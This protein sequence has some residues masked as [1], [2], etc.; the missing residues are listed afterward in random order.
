MNGGRIY[1]QGTLCGSPT[2]S[3]FDLDNQSGVGANDMSA[4]LGDFATGNP[5]GRSDYDCSGGLGA[6][7]LSLWLSAFGAGT[8]FVSCAASCP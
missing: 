2:V 8:Q 5:S 7:D 6:N 4:W 1:I 3:A